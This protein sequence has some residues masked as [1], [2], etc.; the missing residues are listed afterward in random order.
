MACSSGDVP[1]A[2]AAS[3]QSE[4]DGAGEGAPAAKQPR[5]RLDTSKREHP[6]WTKARRAELIDFLAQWSKDKINDGLPFFMFGE[7]T[8]EQTQARDL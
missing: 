5:V 7:N 3:S 1:P 4:L 8:G 6:V 2:A